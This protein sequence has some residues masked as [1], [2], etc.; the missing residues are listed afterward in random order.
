MKVLV[1]NSLKFN[2]Q[3]N[4]TGKYLRNKRYLDNQY[5]RVSFRNMNDLLTLMFG[6]CIN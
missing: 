3:S 6:L 2:K 4:F 5:I 1:K